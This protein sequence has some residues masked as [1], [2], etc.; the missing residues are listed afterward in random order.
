M[1]LRTEVRFLFRKTNIGSDM[2][3]RFSIL[4]YPHWYTKKV[5]NTSALYHPGYTDYRLKMEL[6]GT[7]NWYQK[8]IPLNSCPLYNIT[9]NGRGGLET[10]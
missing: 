8:P 9:A 4:Y 2:T 5:K 7:R 10:H 6:I 3:G 1:F